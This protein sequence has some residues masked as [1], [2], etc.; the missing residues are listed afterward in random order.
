M[1]SH[2]GLYTPPQVESNSG[3]PQI[4]T[5]KRK[6]NH[7]KP[8]SFPPPATSTAITIRQS[9]IVVE[10]GFSSEDEE[11]KEE[12][13]ELLDDFMDMASADSEVDEEAR[14]VLPIGE[15]MIQAISPVKDDTQ[16]GPLY[17]VVLKDEDFSQPPYACQRSISRRLEGKLLN[18]E[19]FRAG[20]VNL[21]RYSCYVP[22]EAFQLR[23]LYKRHARVP[24]KYVLLSQYA[25][26]LLR[27]K[28]DE[29]IEI[30][31]QLGAREIRRCDKEDVRTSVTAK[32]SFTSS[33]FADIS[34]KGS[35][36][37]TKLRQRDFTCLYENPSR[38]RPKIGAIEDYLFYE[39]WKVIVKARQSNSGLL[40]HN[41]NFTF[42]CK[43]SLSAK[44]SAKLHKLG[45]NVEGCAQT[46]T[47]VS[48]SYEV[49]FFT[50]ED[51]IAG[52]RQ[53]IY[54][55]DSAKVRAFLV[56]LELQQYAPGFALTGIDLMSED[57]R[58]YLVSYHVSDLHINRLMRGIQ[59][60]IEGDTDFQ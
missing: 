52:N 43:S 48:D 23:T 44:L 7:Q 2:V 14:L 21:G 8:E 4:S 3:E 10:R 57:L 34:G 45:I 28:E 9:D 19:A 1:E 5:K 55:W 38:T 40:W 24:N 17:L 36:T 53:N 20:D 15:Q 47:D 60:Q 18:L 41:V 12:S 35:K 25:E 51:Y 56:H 39:D 59:L 27:V 50:R 31:H 49:S 42:S 37:E 33:L 13:G 46:S 32:T 22:N 30:M 11:R 26:S 16:E 58:G 29:F 54:L 6:F